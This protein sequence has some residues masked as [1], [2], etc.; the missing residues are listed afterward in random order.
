MQFGPTRPRAKSWTS[1]ERSGANTPS[2]SSFDS[3]ALS[4]VSLR[5][6][7]ATPS[8]F[9]RASA[10]VQEGADPIGLTCLSGAHMYRLPKVIE[11]LRERGAD[12]IVVFGGGTIPD[13]DIQKL[14]AAG[15]AAVFTPGAT[16]GEAIEFVKANVRKKSL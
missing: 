6:R 2:R 15:I 14:K 8:G 12:D 10:A 16:T 1:F 3:H 9:L 11:L 7:G 5:G 4:R 13:E